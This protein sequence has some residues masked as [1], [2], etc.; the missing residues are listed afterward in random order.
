M[1]RNNIKKVRVNNE[2]K[3]ALTEILDRELRDERVHPMTS[4]LSV[5]VTQDLKFCKVEVSVLGNEEDMAETEEG[6]NAAKGFIRSRL[7][8]KLN[9]RN[10]PELTF[11]MNDNIDYAIRMADLIDEV[12]REDKSE[13]R[14]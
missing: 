5:Q 2:V 8:A 1:K 7:A 3:R 12:I 14:D 10:T 9:M 11:V 4:V 6:L 13:S